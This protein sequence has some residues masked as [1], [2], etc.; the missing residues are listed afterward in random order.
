MGLPPP[1]PCSVLNWI[2]WTLPP[3]KIPGYA[4]VSYNTICKHLG[5][6][7][8]LKYKYLLGLF[9]QAWRWPNKGR[10]MSPW[11]Y[12]IVIVH[13]IKCCVIDWH[14]VF[15]SFVFCPKPVKSNRGIAVEIQILALWNKSLFKG[16]GWRGPFQTWNVP[17]HI[18]NSSRWVNRAKWFDTCGWFHGLRSAC[19]VLCR[20]ARERVM[21]VQIAC[22]GC[23]PSARRR[24]RNSKLLESLGEIWLDALKLRLSELWSTKPCWDCAGNTLLSC[25]WLKMG[26]SYRM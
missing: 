26:F 11:Q 15:I 22:W 14:V 24:Y 23:G 16:R 4:T 10:N 3:N 20:G 8:A 12:I 5:S 21:H 13:K 25:S 1:D 17:T 2:C 9:S 18:I 6:H 19:I 7:N